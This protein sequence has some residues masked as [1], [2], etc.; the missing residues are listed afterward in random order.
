[1]LELNLLLFNITYERK[2]DYRTTNKEAIDADG[3]IIPFLDEV[4]G[5]FHVINFVHSVKNKTNNT[6]P[7]KL[8]TFQ[9]L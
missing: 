3:I 5:K 8:M 7:T 1:M 2:L 6:L 9:W 4:E